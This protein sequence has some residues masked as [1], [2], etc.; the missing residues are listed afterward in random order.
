MRKTTF[1]SDRISEKFTRSQ[2]KSYGKALLLY[3]NLQSQIRVVYEGI[4][5]RLNKSSAKSAKVRKK[6]AIKS[7]QRQDF[8]KSRKRPVYEGNN[9]FDK[10]S[11][12]IAEFKIKSC[13]KTMRESMLF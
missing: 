5:F 10:I 7:W 8:I 9:F 3:Q 11:A 2:I 4:D 13:P 1:V 12:K 6:V